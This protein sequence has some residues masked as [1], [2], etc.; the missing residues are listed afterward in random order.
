[1]ETLKENSQSYSL[2]ALN[3]VN[4]LGKN[5]FCSDKALSLL[6]KSDSFFK[7]LLN[8]FNGLYKYAIT[9]EKFEQVIKSLDTSRIDESRLFC[10]AELYSA[11]VKTMEKN[12]YVLPDYSSVFKQ[13]LICANKDIEKIRLLLKNLFN[14]KQ[15]FKIEQIF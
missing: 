12:S 14:K 9:P 6:T 2:F 5:I 4:S 15:P 1:M 7:E 11:Y 8:T 10:V 13:D 3:I